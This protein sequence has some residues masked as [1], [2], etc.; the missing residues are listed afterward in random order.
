[1]P[2]TTVARD[3]NHDGNRSVNPGGVQRGDRG[4]IGNGQPRRIVDGTS[5]TMMSRGS[6][7]NGRPQTDRNIRVASGDFNNDNFNRRPRAVN[8]VVFEGQDEP[9]WVRG[10]RNSSVNA[11][12][13]SQNVGPDIHGN[14]RPKGFINTTFDDESY[15]SDRN[16]SPRPVQGNQI[17]T[18]GNGFYIDDIVIGVSPRTQRRGRSN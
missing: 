16:G 3:T 1:M 6:I 2:R 14:I 17:G 18:D 4:T 12:G 15:R 8:S 5:N 10:R 11:V 7:V 9:L 13:T